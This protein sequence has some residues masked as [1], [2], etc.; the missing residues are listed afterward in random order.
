MSVK[1]TSDTLFV[2]KSELSII[3]AFARK[4]VLKYEN[5]KRIDYMYSTAT[6]I[7]FIKF[8]DNDNKVIRFEFAKSANEKIYK[9]VELL[10]GTV[11]EL[12]VNETV[13]DDLKFYQRNLFTII[14]SFVLG[15]PLGLIG[16]F[17]MW[18]YKKSSVAGRMLVTFMT[19]LFW[20]TC[21]YLTYANYKSAMIDANAALNEYSN[22]LNGAYSSM[23]ASVNGVVQASIIGEPETTKDK[24]IEPFSVGDVYESD[25]VKIMYI[26]S[27]DY[28][29]ENEY[30]QPESGNKYIFAEFSIENVGA[31]DYS[32]GSVLYDCYADDTECKQSIIPAEGIL[33]TITSLPPGKNT[34]GKI[35]FEVPV[36]ATSI[37][38]EYTT[39]SLTGEKVK[40]TFK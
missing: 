25:D 26:N 36:N 10:K 22:A 28:S 8:T 19:L 27:G 13:A 34:K 16:I 11:D 37:E 4:K 2:K 6:E 21:G 7:G 38:L 20:G 14:I 17:L 40:F 1:G 5:L 29:V 33:T 32:T 3:T 39:N 12:I 15:F 35:F 31:T 18:Y 23:E 24:E 9:T 30:M